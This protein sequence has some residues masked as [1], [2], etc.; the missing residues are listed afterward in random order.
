MGYYTRYDGEIKV[1]NSPS[2]AD[3]NKISALFKSLNT[4]WGDCGITLHFQ[5]NNKVHEWKED[6]FR[7]IDFCESRNIK[8]NGRIDF[9]GEE[10]GD[11]W[12]VKIEDNKLYRAETEVVYKDFKEVGRK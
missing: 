12:A 3:G 1:S 5:G 6:L 8:A 4:R 7:L 9:Q 2:I 10:G 11:I